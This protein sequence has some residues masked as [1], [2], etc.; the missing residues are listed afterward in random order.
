[1]A[2][3]NEWEKLEWT[4]LGAG[5]LWTRSAPSIRWV[6]ENRKGTTTLTRLKGFGD[7]TVRRVVAE[8][9]ESEAK[10]GT[11]EGFEF[12]IMGDE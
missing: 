11:L 6:V 12:I 4:D 7:D 5:V 3:R 9:D 8:K 2:R 1:M 10:R